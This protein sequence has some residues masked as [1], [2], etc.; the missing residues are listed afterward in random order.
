[1]SAQRP[2]ESLAVLNPGRWWVPSGL[3]VAMLLLV[4]GLVLPVMRVQKLVFWKDDYSILTGVKALWDDGQWFLA[5]VIALFS[6]TFPILKLAG[7]LG[8]WFSP[9]RRD[10]RGRLLFWVDVLGRWSMLDVFVVAV[11]I[12]VMSSKAALDATPRAGLYVFAAGVG[13]SMVLT[14]AMEQMGRGRRE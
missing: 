1:M 11:T 6:V 5:V 3:V 12:V 2:A 8:V 10:Q 7:L 13:L 14:M 9:M 4:A